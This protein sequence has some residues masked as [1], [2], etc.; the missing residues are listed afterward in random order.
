MAEENLFN[1]IPGSGGIN[2]PANQE[3][4]DGA[5]ILGVVQV[6]RGPIRITPR[7]N[8]LEPGSCLAGMKYT[9]PALAKFAT[10]DRVIYRNL[11]LCTVLSSFVHPQEGENFYEVHMDGAL[12][13]ETRNV[14]EVSLAL[15]PSAASSQTVH[16]VRSNTY[17]KGQD[18]V[19]WTGTAG[20]VRVPLNATVID[21]INN[22]GSLLA[23]AFQY[24]VELIDTGNIWP[25]LVESTDLTPRFS[26]AH[27]SQG[28]NPPPP[29]MIHETPFSGP[30]NTTVQ[31]DCFDSPLSGSTRLGPMHRVSSPNDMRYP[32][33]SIVSPSNAQHI[34]FDFT[35]RSPAS[36]LQQ[37]LH[38]QDIIQ[39]SHGRCPLPASQPGRVTQPVAGPLKTPGHFSTNTSIPTP[40]QG[41]NRVPVNAEEN[42][43]NR[44]SSSINPPT[45]N[46]MEIP[47]MQRPDFIHLPTV[48]AEEIPPLNGPELVNLPADATDVPMPGVVAKPMG[49]HGEDEEDQIAEGVEGT[50]D[51]SYRRTMNVMRAQS[52]RDFP[53]DTTGIPEG[54]FNTI[55]DIDYALTCWA[56]EQHKHD[57]GFTI[58]KGGAKEA[59]KTGSKQHGERKW[60]ICTDCRKVCTAH[61][62]T[63]TD[64]SAKITPFECI[65]EHCQEGWYFFR[66][67]ATHASHPFKTSAMEIRIDPNSR[68]M[69]EEI[70]VLAR[71]MAAQ[72][73]DASCIM[74][75][76]AG[77]ANRLKIGVTWTIEY[78]RTH[79]VL[80]TSN[81]LLDAT[82]LV[83][84]L[85]TRKDN[86]GLEF[87][88]DLD[89][90]LM[91][92]CFVQMENSFDEWARGGQTNVLFVDAT[93]GTNQAGLKLCCFTTIS[94]TGQ[95]VILAFGL[96]R[97]EDAMSYEWM[98]RRFH[99]IFKV[100]PLV[101]F[102]DSAVEIAIA[103]DEVNRLDHAAT[104]SGI[105]DIWTETQHFLC[106]YHISRNL[107]KNCHGFFTGNPAGWR[108]FCN[109][110]WR[111][112]LQSDART[113][114]SIM[115]DL[116]DLESIMI[117]EC[118]IDEDEDK[119]HSGLKWLRE[120][121]TR[122][123][124][125]W[126]ARFTWSYLTHGAH[127]SQRAE[128]IHKAIKKRIN[129][130]LRVTEL[131][132]LLI[133]YNLTSRDKKAVNVIFKMTKV[134]AATNTDL[135]P[136][137]VHLIKPVMRITPYALNH[138]LAQYAQCRHYA[139]Q[140]KVEYSPI[141]KTEPFFQGL[142]DQHFMDMKHV[143]HDASRE[144]DED[145]PLHGY[146]ATYYL[147]R[148]GH[149]PAVFSFDG[150]DTS[151]TVSDATTVACDFGLQEGPEFD[152]TPNRKCSMYVCSCQLDTALNLP[153][154]HQLWCW[155]EKQRSSTK[156]LEFPLAC[157]GAKWKI[158]S[159]HEQLVMSNALRDVGTAETMSQDFE[160][161]NSNDVHRPAYVVPRESRF[162][163][164]LRECQTLAEMSVGSQATFDR[165]RNG[166]R[167]LVV[168]VS[169]ATTTPTLV[170]VPGGTPPTT[171]LP[172]DEHSM[173]VILG[174]Q[175]EVVPFD[176]AKPLVENILGFASTE[177]EVVDIAIKYGGKKQGKWVVGS[178][179]DLEDKD[180]EWLTKTKTLKLIGRK[181]SRANYKVWYKDWNPETE[182]YD[183][184]YEYE[185][186]DMRDYC[187]TGLTESVEKFK[188]CLLRNK[189]AGATDAQLQ[190]MT[191]GISRRQTQKRKGG[192]GDKG[193]TKRTKT[194]KGGK[195]R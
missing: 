150:D 3:A 61:N 71:D 147:T 102:T 181:S 114:D 165:I 132:G 186:L 183:D 38:R 187:T 112:C 143:I 184:K 148:L 154:R 185:Y 104:N 56:G 66:A 7:H 120:T 12:H 151:S 117:N 48:D 164:T 47:H 100:R 172:A 124:K 1:F 50:T 163:L 43:Q 46:A 189:P 36:Q 22:S 35:D 136:Y 169:T 108:D 86:Q 135:P 105:D 127:S 98:F 97:H 8:K 137:L 53:D 121:L 195:K 62:K 19:F 44:G 142:G 152:H 161:G 192:Q 111:I 174:C 68:C 99:D 162:Q 118:E 194:K 188:W 126:A 128:S 55:G 4:G 109:K 158:L 96:I 107:H 65:Y 6:S 34:R 146:L 175:L 87:F 173:K 45:V 89:G 103:F 182:V 58:T 140:G 73:K 180:E 25:V 131:V 27:P 168:K 116:T 84:L 110:F 93:H 88:F 91:S 60:F 64:K 15:Y 113:K 69:P 82:D 31:R 160:S 94:S 130:G 159:S 83:A 14:D 167:E 79:F 9:A 179:F 123:Y 16:S 95:T 122:K 92:R 145:L 106:T 156:V 166:I 2:N 13:G 10:G 133:A 49:I 80:N 129:R 177:E 72:G 78:I 52:T 176:E 153:C 191:M 59:V 54:P 178:V 171:R 21:V 119:Q 42:P 26:S 17:Y 190:K 37:S 33:C 85:R 115:Q 170:E 57:R 141:L 90:D 40:L 134:V 11:K 70:A 77:S 125:Q 81:K 23:P 30:V 28:Y 29:Q 39:E 101:M 155:E 32:T 149:V 5:E 51:L 24:K 193:G 157:I 76:L 63:V 144:D 75:V 41:V 67:T 139:S 138:L 18:V 20:G 74:D